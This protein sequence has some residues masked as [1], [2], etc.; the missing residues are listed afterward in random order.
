[1]LTRALTSKTVAVLSCVF[2]LVVGIWLGAHPRFLPG[3]VADVLAGSQDRRVVH[4]ALD[5]IHDKNY[6]EV[7]RGELC[8]DALTGAVADLKDRFS[9]YFSK[10]QYARFNEVLNNEF[11]GIGT[12]VRDVKD[13]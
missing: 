1:M 13:G 5:T 9:A 12:G 3:P 7:P 2:V 4:E 6:R 8:D 11:S 10:Q